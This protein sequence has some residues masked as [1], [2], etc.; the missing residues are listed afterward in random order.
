MGI[1]PTQRLEIKRL[2]EAGGTIWSASELIGIINGRELDVR[3]R[4]A[5]HV[6]TYHN[7]Q[8]LFFVSC[9]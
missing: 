8:A 6:Q 7:A 5:D 4:L 3:W 9:A 1:E 2:P